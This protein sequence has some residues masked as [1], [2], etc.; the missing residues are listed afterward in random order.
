VLRRQLA[1]RGMVEPSPT[2]DREAPHR[3]HEA[4]GYRR[5][6][7]RGIPRG[8]AAGLRA[9]QGSAIANRPITARL[10]QLLACAYRGSVLVCL[11][12]MLIA[13]R[14]TR[15]SG[16][17]RREL[18]QLVSDQVGDA[19]PMVHQIEVTARQHVQ[20]RRPGGVQLPRACLVK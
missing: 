3:W 12:T 17:W 20:L 11:V 14:G 2:L 8:A 10:A 15:H 18:A 6:A 7:S 19:G 5:P 13:L 9:T 1:S 16:A 4:G